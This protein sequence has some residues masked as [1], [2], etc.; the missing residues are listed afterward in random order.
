MIDCYREIPSPQ[1][2]R[3]I[4]FTRRSLGTSLIWA[5][6]MEALSLQYLHGVTMEV[7]YL[8]YL[9]GLTASKVK[10]CYWSNPSVNLENWPIVGYIYD[11]KETKDQDHEH[12]PYETGRS[13]VDPSHLSTYKLGRENA[14]QL[15]V[16]A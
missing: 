5:R 2:N 11:K 12:D 3:N 6:A 16:M 14:S 8:Q 15:I 13:L 10:I 7:L 1:S 9:H 4:A